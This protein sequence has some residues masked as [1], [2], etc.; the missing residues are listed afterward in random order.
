MTVSLYYY[1]VH[2]V[3]VCD[4]AKYFYSEVNGYLKE[5]G[6]TD[7]GTP[8]D[9]SKIMDLIDGY[10]GEGYALS[11]DEELSMLDYQ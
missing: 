6:L 10:K 7:N 4:E 3:C 2:G 5:F 9:S 1:R 11:T 8:I